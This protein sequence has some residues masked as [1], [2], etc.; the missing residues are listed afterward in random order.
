MSSLDALEAVNVAAINDDEAVTLKTIPSPGAPCYSF[1]LQPSFPKSPSNDIT[2]LMTAPQP[3]NHSQDTGD[4]T[5][6][7]SRAMAF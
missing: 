1:L 6:I 2:Q 5:A 3:Y 7:K 4:K